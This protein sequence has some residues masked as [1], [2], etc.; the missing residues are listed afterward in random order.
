MPPAASAEQAPHGGEGECDELDEAQAEGEEQAGSGRE[1]EAGVEVG[2]DMRAEP[3]LVSGSD[4]AVWAAA[5]AIGDA[6]ADTFEQLAQ[7]RRE[8]IQ[9]RSRLNQQ[10]KLEERK[11]ARRV[12][13]ARGL[14]DADLLGIIAA[15]ATAKMKAMAK[16]KAK[17]KGKAHAKGGSKGKAN[18]VEVS[19]STA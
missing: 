16:A 10:I 2:G 11:R 17:Q 7:R 4:G 15:R 8:L 6:S 1:A 9:E 5:A 14:T 19:D 12:E 18:A 3:S 13:R